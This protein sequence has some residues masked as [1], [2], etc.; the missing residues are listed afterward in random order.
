MKK[1]V[2]ANW[3]AHPENAAK[4][5]ALAQDTEVAIAAYKNA[6]V[7]IAPPFPFLPVV[8]SL[9]TRARLGSQDVWGA[10]GPYTGMVSARQLKSLG[11]GYVI[12]GH[13][14]RRIHAGE[15][16]EMIHRKVAAVLRRGLKPVLCIGER[17]RQ[18][19]EVPVIVGVQLSSAL[20]GLK[21][22]W[23]GRLIVAYE[24][25][26]AISTAAGSTGAATPDSAFRAR[27]Y[28]EKTLV[29]LFGART[30]R[31]V[32]II[33]GGSVTPVNIAAFLAE[34]RMNGVLVGSASLDA[35]KFGQIVRSAAEVA[36]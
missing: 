8:G 34:S 4:A 31:D 29:S 17:E 30:A 26:W 25:V 10:E 28:I 6:E 16:D 23:L 27:I 9:L 7:V 1:L 3:K 18:G 36:R 2:I 15:T 20:K 35:K 19:G 5:R 12:V 13:S 33:Y 22:E 11:V 24:P 32:R 14:E 21:K